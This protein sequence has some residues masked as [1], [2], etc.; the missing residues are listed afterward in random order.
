MQLE[1]KVTIITGSSGG[2]GEALC[3]AFAREGAPVFM[4]DLNEENG[5][6]IESRLR[7]QGYKAW[8]YKADVSSAKDTEDVF[9]KIIKMYDHIDI[10]INNAGMAYKATI[11]TLTE[12][13][14]DRQIAVNMKSVYLYSHRVIPIMFTLLP[15]KEK[16]ID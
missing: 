12:E 6:K 11:E 13:Q 8:F 3:N 14:W 16:E 5:R 4:V 7:G 1:N 10:L 15:M 2:I 9:G